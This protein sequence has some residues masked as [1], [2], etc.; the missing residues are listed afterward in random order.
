MSIDVLEISNEVLDKILKIADGGIVLTQRSIS[1]QLRFS[2]NKIDIIKT[3]RETSINML[4]EKDQKV[5]ILNIT[6][7][8]LEDIDKIMEMAKI[9]LEKSQPKP[10]YAPIPEPSENYP[11]IEGKIDTDTRDK[12]EKMSEIAKKIIDTATSEGAKRVA[13]SIRGNYIEIGLAT[14]SGTQLKDG[15]TNAILDVRAFNNGTATGH[16]SQIA[17]GFNKLNPEKVSL[18][19]AETSKL[20][21]VQKTLD[22]GRYDTLLTPNAVAGI[23]NLV[24]GSSSAF[25]VL[26]GFSFFRDKVGKNVAAENFNL[27]DNPLNIDSA[28]PRSFDDEGVPTRKNVLIENGVLKTLLHNR[29]TAK[30]FNTEHTGN[31][32]WMFPNPWHL[33]V[34]PGDAKRE[35]LLEQLNKGIIVNNITYI[36]FQNYVQGDFS[37][38]IRDGVFYVENGEIKHAVKGLRFSDN[39][40]RLLSNINGIGSDT[41]NIFHWWLEY[42]TPVYTPS[43][44][45][46]ECGFTKAHGER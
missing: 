26:M 14:S 29:F 3:W 2:Q 25:S 28:R 15:Y 36:R 23:M 37:G 9:A 13:G 43:L 5:N 46:K 38:I 16:S 1:H 6:Y 7:P 32:G 39:A 42:D 4:L 27:I 30:A 19:A 11:K 18:E 34:L 44:L 10:I 40:L 45:V 12:P 31:A 17:R 22:P 33:Y 24:A 21:T 20:N 8:G 35:E 41:E